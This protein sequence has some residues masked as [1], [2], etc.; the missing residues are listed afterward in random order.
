MEI[1]KPE[2]VVREVRFRVQN[3]PYCG[4]VLEKR[5]P[6]G[7]YS[8]ERIIRIR[9]ARRGTYPLT[10]SQASVRYERLT[11]ALMQAYEHGLADPGG[12]GV[13]RDQV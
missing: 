8:L 7:R 12:D 1:S 11:E 3:R 10:I 13:E 2:R 5:G 9:F 4:E 6:D